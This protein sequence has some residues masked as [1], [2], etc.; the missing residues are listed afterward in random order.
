MSHYNKDLFKR[1]EPVQHHITDTNTVLNISDTMGHS[2]RP[3][4]LRSRRTEIQNSP[5]SDA[6][7]K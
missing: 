6:S 7:S 1:Y 5:D 3:A 2:T 4:D